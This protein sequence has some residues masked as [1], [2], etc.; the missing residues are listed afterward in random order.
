MSIKDAAKMEVSD[1]F[2]AISKEETVQIDGGW[3]QLEDDGWNDLDDDSKKG[4]G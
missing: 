1:T 4:A 2:K 3:K